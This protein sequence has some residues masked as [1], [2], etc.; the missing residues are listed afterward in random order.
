MG[1]RLVLLLLLVSCS[2]SN[3]IKPN[4]EE[5]ERERILGTSFSVLKCDKPRVSPTAECNK[6]PDSNGQYTC[7]ERGL[8]WRHEI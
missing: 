4:C 5:I 2:T 7:F 3:N 6:K 8:W 1:R